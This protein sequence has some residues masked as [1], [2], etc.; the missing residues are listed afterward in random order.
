MVETDFSKPS[1]TILFQ[2][3]NV[4]EVHQA[5]Q[6]HFVIYNFSFLA[7]FPVVLCSSESSKTEQCVVFSFLCR[8]LI[9]CDGNNCMTFRKKKKLLKYFY[10]FV[11]FLFSMLDFLQK[12]FLIGKEKKR[13]HSDF[14]QLELMLYC[15]D[16]SS[17]KEA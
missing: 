13:I 16:S 15:K 1:K 12:F 11:H 4:A 3:G 7:S 2:Y 9:F 8:K 14:D 6:L 17:E 5:L 10:T